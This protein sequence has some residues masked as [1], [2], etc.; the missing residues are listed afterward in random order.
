M[1]IRAVDNN[2]ISYQLPNMT[3]TNCL[4]V[5]RKLGGRKTFAQDTP[6]QG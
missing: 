2:K 4:L 5:H 3:V 1:V 6:S